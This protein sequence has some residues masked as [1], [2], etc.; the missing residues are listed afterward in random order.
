MKFACGMLVFLRMAF[1]DHRRAHY[2]EHPK[3][4]LL[5]PEQYASLMLELSPQLTYFHSAN[6]VNIPPGVMMFEGVIV[7]QSLEPGTPKLI[8]CKNEVIYL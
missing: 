3:K 5:H 2:G 8:N 6:Q 4:I 1:S 7:E